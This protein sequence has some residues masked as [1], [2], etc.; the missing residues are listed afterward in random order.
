MPHRKLCYPNMNDTH[1][2]SRVTAQYLDS[3][4]NCTNS[5]MHDYWES[6]KHWSL[7]FLMPTWKTRWTAISL[8]REIV[9]VHMLTFFVP[10]GCRQ[11]VERFLMPALKSKQWPK[12]KIKQYNTCSH[13]WFEFRR[14]IWT[15]TELLTG[16]TCCSAV[17]PCLCL[18]SAHWHT[19]TDRAPSRSRSS[20]RICTAAVLTYLTSRPGLARCNV[21][22]V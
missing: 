17:S 22:N 11:A 3:K 14:R 15:L 2:D 20:S 21:C 13:Q 6:L 5:L 1:K 7:G 10:I 4:S 9:M 8:M 12:I 18:V 19:G 16:I